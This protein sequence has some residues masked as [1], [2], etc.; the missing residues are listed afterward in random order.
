MQQRTPVCLRQGPGT[1]CG[2]EGQEIGA[3]RRQARLA[4]PASNGKSGGGEVARKGKSRLGYPLW[5]QCGST[6]RF[7]AS[8]HEGQ[9][10][11]TASV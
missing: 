10:E 1:C 2:R 9:T 7:P 11:S 5:A 3:E 8:T 6:V 4:P